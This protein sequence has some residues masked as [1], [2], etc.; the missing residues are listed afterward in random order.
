MTTVCNLITAVDLNKALSS[1]EER[2]CICVICFLADDSC[3]RAKVRTSGAFKHLLQVA[4][5]TDS[6]SLLTMVIESVIRYMVS[7]H[8]NR[9]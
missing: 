9:I 1:S 6:D 2:H 4:K 7:V 5:N 3:N 8:R